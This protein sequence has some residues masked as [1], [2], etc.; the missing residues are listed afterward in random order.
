MLQ[1]FL[2]TALASDEGY[3]V[4]KIQ[5]RLPAFAKE[6]VARDRGE[7]LVVTL[8]PLLLSLPF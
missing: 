7:L 1:A 6:A 4:G 2:G 3:P 5:M 8:H